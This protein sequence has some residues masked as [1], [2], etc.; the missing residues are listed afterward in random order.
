MGFLDKL[1]SKFRN[2]QNG[3]SNQADAENLPSTESDSP[4]YG[5]Q[6]DVD[7]MTGERDGGK[8]VLSDDELSD[9]SEGLTEEELALAEAA[10]EAFY[11]DSPYLK[12]E[13]EVE[14]AVRLKM[15]EDEREQ[16]LQDGDASV[17]DPDA[18]PDSEGAS[19]DELSADAGDGFPADA[20]SDDDGVTTDEPADG[21][22]GDGTDTDGR[23]DEST[24]ENAG[25]TVDDEQE[26]VSFWQ[27]LKN[28]LKKTRS[29]L[30]S[31]VEAML[32]AMTKIDDD[33]FDEL[34]EILITADVGVET[35]EAILDELKARV[36]DGRLKDKDQIMSSLRQIMVEM[37]GEDTPLTLGPSL[38]VVLVI[39]VNGAGKTTSIGKIA[40][41]LKKQGKTVVVAAAD[42]FRAA[43][44]DQLAVWC[45]RAGVEMVSQ[46]EGSDP[47]AVVFDAVAAAKKRHADVLL[48]DTAG[49]LQNKKNLMNEL[50]KIDRVIDRELPGATRETLLVLDATTGQNAVSQ[51][52]E[53]SKAAKITGITLNKL[54][55]SAKGGIV[56]SIHNELGIPVKFV[57]VGEKIDDMR[58][59]S[60]RDFVD[61][62]FGD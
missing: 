19:D 15:E 13:D 56:I 17:T 22:A 42:T 57:G 55:G 1:K 21:I 23:A 29:A 2:S 3:T 40:K 45:Q 9:E 28:G 34:E 38:S 49:R 59:F 60:G 62:L 33:L 16:L 54:D 58:E 4:A 48:I 43:A 24:D 36:K 20:G 6:T 11:E 52:K 61:A 37:I 53:F 25:E 27:A 12:T 10:E 32:K 51:A 39:G 5:E 14:E 7:G 35:T 44:I 50:A 46:S 18:G 30:F 8:D 47:A 41:R 26:K 31:P